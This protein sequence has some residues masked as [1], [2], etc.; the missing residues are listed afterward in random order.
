MRVE[1][2][3]ADRAAKTRTRNEHVRVGK[4]VPCDRLAS[5]LTLAFRTATVSVERL[6]RSPLRLEL[7]LV[8]FDEFCRELG[9]HGLEIHDSTLG[10]GV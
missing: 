5:T 9:V 3:F 10:H 7:V 1:E 2:Q 4:D 8:P 6:E